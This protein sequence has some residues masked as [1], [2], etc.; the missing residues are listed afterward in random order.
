MQIYQEIILEHYRHPKNNKPL[1]QP[2]N[3][4][5]VSNPLC[6]DELRMEIRMDREIIKEIGFVGKGCAI[7]I[8]SAS[9]L[10]DYAKGKTKKHLKTL[11][12]NFMMGL[13]GVNL[14]PNRIKCALLPL[15][16]LIKLL[17]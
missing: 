16:A 8:A 15:E 9:M 6:G 13:L 10:T 3:G 14:G 11:D 4:I 17:I 5:D 2:A 1:K 12:K 7:S